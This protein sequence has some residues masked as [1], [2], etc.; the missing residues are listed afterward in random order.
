MVG[1]VVGTVLA[2]A[3]TR[4]MQAMLHG[5]SA[6]DPRTFVD[7]AVLMVVLALVAAYVPARR[8]TRVDPVITLRG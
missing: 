8:A 3:A 1:V 2:V 4:G 5:V 7:V 6:S